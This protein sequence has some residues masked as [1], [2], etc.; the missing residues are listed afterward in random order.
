MTWWIPGKVTRTPYGT[1]EQY[2]TEINLLLINLLSYTYIVSYSLV[3]L[4]FLSHLAIKITLFFSFFFHVQIGKY[5]PSTLGFWRMCPKKAE[6]FSASHTKTIGPKSQLMNEEIS[7]LRPWK[8]KTVLW[9]KPVQ[10]SSVLALFYKLNLN[11][12]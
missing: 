5:C 12:R 8:Y 6:T 1:L 4:A 11:L 2:C 3:Y 9:W 10:R 7:V